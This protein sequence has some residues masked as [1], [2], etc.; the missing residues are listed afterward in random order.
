MSFPPLGIWWTHSGLLSSDLISLMDRVL[1]LVITE[2]KVQYQ[3]SMNFFSFFSTAYSCR[4]FIQ[5]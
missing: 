2:V 5:L 4:L 3:S 1:C